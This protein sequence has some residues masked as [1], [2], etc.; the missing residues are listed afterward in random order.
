M[1]GAERQKDRSGWTWHVVFMHTTSLMLCW[2]KNGELHVEQSAELSV[3]SAKIV[4]CF[5][6]FQAL[7]SF[8][9]ISHRNAT[10]ESCK[11][12]KTFDCKGLFFSISDLVGQFQ[13]RLNKHCFPAEALLGHSSPREH[14]IG[15]SRGWH[16]P[17]PE[18]ALSDLGEPGV[19]PPLTWL[20]A[21]H[22]RSKEL[23]PE[24]FSTA[25]D[26]WVMGSWDGDT[27]SSTPEECASIHVYAHIQFCI[28][29]GSQVENQSNVLHN[30][31]SCSGF[32]GSAIVLTS[33]SMTTFTIDSL[34]VMLSTAL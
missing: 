20:L 31:I 12:K 29:W 3:C 25:A 21:S 7:F 26:V 4:S 5:I 15:D 11:K 32:Y 9:W 23:L 30:K 22:Q 17:C 10:S 16:A 33:F 13:Y 34:A 8:F 2:A 27:T 1:G 28:C 24:T 19:L 14:S 6:I 18:A